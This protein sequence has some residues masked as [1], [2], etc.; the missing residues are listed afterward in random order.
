MMVCHF[1]IDIESID[2]IQL[3]LDSTC[4]S[5]STD[6]VESPVW[7]VVVAI[8]FSNGVLDL[9][10][11]LKPV[12]IRL[13]SF[14][15]VSFSASTKVANLSL[16]VARP[17]NNEVIIHLKHRFRQVLHISLEFCRWWCVVHYHF[18]LIV[19]LLLDEWGWRNIVDMSWC[20]WY[21]WWQ[22]SYYCSF[23]F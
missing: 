14:Q 16:F 12:Y 1:G 23:L 13:P 3:L 22:R 21:C 11:G 7:L 6:L 17:G 9:F 15:C 20:S 4:L 10:P 2:I 19:T 18:W 5:E 8:I